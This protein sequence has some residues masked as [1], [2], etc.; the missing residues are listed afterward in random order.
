MDH[1]GNHDPVDALR[2]QSNAGASRSGNTR[3]LVSWNNVGIK[4]IEAASFFKGARARMG[5]SLI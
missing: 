3:S 2:E 1:V 5:Q 4:G